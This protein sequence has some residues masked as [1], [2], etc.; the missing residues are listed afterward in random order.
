[1]DALLIGWIAY[2]AYALCAGIG[3]LALTVLPDRLRPV[4]YAL[5]VAWFVLFVGIL[6]KD[7]LDDRAHPPEPWHLHLGGPC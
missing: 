1:M 7:V 4:S 5:P 6:G 2:P 3:T